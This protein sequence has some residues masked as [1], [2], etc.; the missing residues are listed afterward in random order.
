MDIRALLEKGTVL[1]DGGSI[2]ELERRG[3]VQAGPYTPEV[4]IEHPDALAQLHTEFRRAGADVIQAL[5]FYGSGD[6]AGAQADCINRAAVQVARRAA[7]GALVA[8]GLSPTPTFREGK[9]G[10][11]D[12]MRRHLD[13]QLSEGVDL[14]IGETF[15]WLEEALMA[16]QAI[17]ES[18]LFSIVTMNIPASGS[19]DGHS[20]EDCARRLVDAGADVVGTNCTFDPMHSLQVAERMR[21]VVSCPIAC[22]P[23][24]YSSGPEALP[25]ESWPEFPLEMES[26][27]LGRGAMASFARLA[28]QAGVSFIGGCC[29]VAPHQLRAMAEALGRT[30]PASAKSPDLSR[31]MIPE[32]RSRAEQQA[33]TLP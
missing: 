33:A 29:G 2:F 12:L 6:K 17:G 4:A 23:I 8:G 18:G 1:C 26:R 20:V 25:F 13:A 11:L 24:G 30:P 14:V 27:G 16:A 10:T 22:Q 15:C 21:A 5:A 19:R 7:N 28:Q 3:Y 32:V 9:S 31:H